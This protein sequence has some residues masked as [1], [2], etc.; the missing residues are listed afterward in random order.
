M[1]QESEGRLMRFL[2]M[3]PWALNHAVHVV[4]ILVIICLLLDRMVLVGLLKGAS[5]GLGFSHE[6]ESYRRGERR[7]LEYSHDGNYSFTGRKQD[8]FEIW[9]WGVGGHESRFPF[10]FLEDPFRTDDLEYVRGWNF[11]LRVKNEHTAARNLHKILA[12]EEAFRAARG[13]YA[14]SVKE[15][16]DPEKP[17]LEGDWGGSVEGYEFTV[18]GAPDCFAA[19]A[20][21]AMPG[22]TGE[23]HFF[24]DCSGQIRFNLNR[25]A[26]PGDF[27]LHE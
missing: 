12:S 5:K 14:T 7:L 26:G 19:N 20:D 22:V 11:G 4:L 9:T 17:F 1:S 21:P 15:L 24:V 23:R 18:S 27:Q 10:L 16:T 13:M 25:V 3:T 6:T 2:R 8:C